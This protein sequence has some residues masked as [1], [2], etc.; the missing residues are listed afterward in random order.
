MLWAFVGL[1][2]LSEGQQGLELELKIEL[3][4]RLEMDPGLEM[5]LEFDKDLELEIEEDY[6]G[7]R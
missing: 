3:D 2:Q 4:Q 7:A 1:F 5:E 6:G